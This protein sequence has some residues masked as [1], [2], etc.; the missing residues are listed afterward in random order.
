MVYIHRCP[1]SSTSPAPDKLLQE[2]DVVVTGNVASAIVC[3]PQKPHPL[4]VAL[5]E[6]TEPHVWVGP[7]FDE[8]AA[9]L[10]VSR[11][12]GASALGRP[13]TPPAA[14]YGGSGFCW[15]ALVRHRDWFGSSTWM[16]RHRG[17]MIG[18]LLFCRFLPQPSPGSLLG[19]SLPNSRPPP[20][21]RHHVV[22][23][24]A[25][26]RQSP[27]DVAHILW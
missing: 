17:W 16:P 23:P 15:R 8:L 24:I 26:H 18:H 27:S 10:I 2:V 25:L 12:V 7:M 5:F 11:S 21:R 14:P 19:A 4:T 9:S 3:C 20:S 13:S 1:P 22:E 6:G